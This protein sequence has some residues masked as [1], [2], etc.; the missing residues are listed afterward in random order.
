MAE[1]LNLVQLEGA[2]I[3]DDCTCLTGTRDTT[4]GIRDLLFLQRRRRLYFCTRRPRV[5]T[6]LPSIVP[7]PKRASQQ[8]HVAAQLFV[9]YH[10]YDVT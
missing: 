1:L 8:R 3:K 6:V 2:A 5:F 7:S 4:R 10:P 9:T